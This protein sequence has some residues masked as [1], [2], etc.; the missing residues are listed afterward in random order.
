MSAQRRVWGMAAQLYALRSQRNWGL[1]DFSDLKTLVDLSARAGAGI[2]GVNPVHALFPHNPPHASPYSPSSR[3]F[4]NILY[5]DVEAVADYAE[6]DAARHR[7]LDPQFQARLRALRAAELIDYKGAA[8]AKFEILEQLYLHFRHHHLAKGGQR[9]QAFRSFQAEGGEALRR[10]ALFEALQQHFFH[11]D[12]SIWGWPA[13]P[14]PY[15]DPSGEAVARFAAERSERVEYF[16]YL[17]WQAALQL[18]AAGRRSWEHGLGVGL[19]QDLALGVDRGG[20]EAWA[21]QGLYALGA[22][23]GAPPDDFNLNGQDWGLPPMIPRRLVDAAY[24]PFIATLRANMRHAG[25]LRIDHVMGLMRLFWI[26]AGSMPAA[27]AYVE[28]PLEDLIGIVALESRR[29]RCL[30]IG[31]DLGT[32]PDAMREAMVRYGVLMYRLLYFEKE[33]D[34]GF[35]LPAAYPARALAAVSTHDLPTLGGYWVGD[36]LD[37]RARLSLFPSE[38][39]RQQ[40]IVTRARDLAQLLVALEREQLLPAEASI[41]P[42][43][44]PGMSAELARAVHVYLAR[45]PSQIMMVRPEDFLG[46]VEQINVPGSTDQYPNWKRK[47]PLNIE[48]W[49]ADPRF[50]ALAD[51]LR[52]ERGSAVQPRAQPAAARE[53]PAPLRVPVATYRLQFNHGFTFTQAAELAPYLHELGIS[54]CYC[55]PYLKARPGSIHGYDIIDHNALNPEIGSREDFERFVTTLKE[56]GMGQILDIVPNHMGV[57]GSD[58]GWWLDVLENGQASVYAGYFDIDWE[59]FNE[60]LRG[61]VLLP[62]LGEHYGTVLN[63]GG[64]QLGFDG[65]RGEFSIHYVDHRFPIDPRE[66]PRILGHQADR[67]ISRLGTENAQGLEFQSL[68]TAFGHL[69]SRSETAPEKVAERNRDKEIHKRHL[70]DLCQRSPD[71]M[72]L[73]SENINE[74]NGISGDPASFDLLHQLIKAQ[75]FRLAYWRVASDEINYRRF[76][77]INDLAALRM[78]NEAV[79][80]ATHRLIFELVAAGKADGLR[81]DHPDGLNDPGQYFQRLQD[82]FAAQSPS[83]GADTETAPPSGRSLYLVIEKILAEFERLPEGWRVHGTTGYRFLNVVNGLFVDNEAEARLDRIYAKF[84][85]ERVD[86]TE[87]LYRCKR[88]IMRT[89][90]ASELTVLANQL[91]RIAQAD[92]DTCDFTLNSLRDA[93]MEIVA[94]FPVYRSYITATGMSPEDR[95]YIDW[96]AAVAKEKSRAADVTVFDFVRDVLTTA[97]G[98]GRSPGYRDMVASFAMKFQ[99]FTAP[100]MAKGVEDTGFYSYNRLVSLNEVGGDPRTFGFTVAAF[101]GASQDRAANW[102]HT[103]VTTSTHDTKRSEDVRARINVLSE[104][105]AIWKLRLSRWSRLNR[106]RKR[107]VDK[108]PAPSRNDE[109]LLY[110]TL[111]GIWPL[112]MPDQKRLHALGERVEAYMLKVVREAKIHSSWINPNSAYEEALR[113]FVQAL[114]GTVE[115]N[116]FLADFMPLA[117]VVSRFGMYNSL[118]QTLIKLVSPGVPDIYQGNELWEFSLVDPDNR[119]PVDYRQRQLL[120]QEL[121]TLFSIPPGEVAGRVRGLLDAMEDGRAKLYVTWR[122]LQFRQRWPQLFQKGEYVPLVAEGER[123]RHV[124]AFA[125]RHESMGV[126][127]VAPRLFAALAGDVEKLPASTEAWGDT[128]IQ[129]PWLAAGEKLCNVIDGRTFP[130]Q[131]GEE[132]RRLPVGPL[133]A[134]FPVALLQYGIQP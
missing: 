20:G 121:K 124:V 37:T 73:V 78:E 120:L 3:L 43:A 17:Q 89:S 112:E 19:Y 18:E 11:D 101:H 83:G 71:V 84:I 81:I 34:G 26:P 118:S 113:H 107:E 64:L 104:M 75:A 38:E 32:V 58:N 91:G 131:E 46:Q 30:V 126:I 49:P 56:R 67:I 68:V 40:Q 79:F 128:A 52:A 129:I 119:R 8:A 69:P 130:M 63:N 110:Q 77:D 116:P 33:Q 86:F 102:P 28:Y 50:M 6:C 80:E 10:Q 98:E 61:K 14:E 12:P 1:G 103:M 55:S 105:P 108:R 122:A 4:L 62:V 27:G 74:F 31:E 5:L 109:Y 45:A 111:L 2:V 114:L 47:L 60:E 41:H 53:L 15:R 44:H 76:F 13:W 82:R 115:R 23:M 99:Q 134:D 125:R 59:P 24:A 123:A 51:A 72:R 90:L 57:L 70:A 87:L 21:N 85:D 132:G 95:R 93:L 127:A 36:D 9:T 100:V 39:A 117:R 94:C 106:N 92:R 29:N 16:E 48:E 88:L 97:I 22:S 25:A 35:K 65:E 7:V 133:V 42:V 96:A 54:H 66:Y